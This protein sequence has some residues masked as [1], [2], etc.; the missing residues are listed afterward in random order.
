[1]EDTT[2]ELNLSEARSKLTQLDKILNPG[3]ALQ[4][5]RRGKPYAR[6]KLLA[7]MDPYERILALIEELP[8]PKKELKPVAE[9]YKSLH[10]R[11]KN[12]DA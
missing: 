7:G 8:E 6:V 3:D 10:Y 4:I 1:M 9:N 5:N 12:A 2:Q 11:S